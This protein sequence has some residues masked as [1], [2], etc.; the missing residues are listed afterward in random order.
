MDGD[1]M[2]TGWRITAITISALMGGGVLWLALGERDP[3]TVA[4]VEYV[5][6]LPKEQVIQYTA[7][8]QA[9]SKLCRLEVNNSTDQIVYKAAGIRRSK[10]AKDAG[11][12]ATFAKA[13]EA[14]LAR[15]NTVSR[16]TLCDKAVELFGEQGS[17]LPGL[18]I[19]E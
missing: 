19:T 9:Y 17:A 6:G 15:G 7:E 10:L 8:A 4:F 18:L 1:E 13:H 5:A 16:Q 14:A 3:Q 12:H 2:I 11:I